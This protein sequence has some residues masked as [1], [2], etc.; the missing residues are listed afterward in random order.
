MV[1]SVFNW[2]MLCVFAMHW[3]NPMV[4]LSF[5]CVCNVKK[6]NIMSKN[7]FYLSHLNY[8]IQ[9]HFS[10]KCPPFVLVSEGV[11]FHTGSHAKMVVLTIFLTSLFDV[12]TDGGPSPY[13]NTHN[14]DPTT[15]GLNTI[16]FFIWLF[17]IFVFVLLW[18]HRAYSSIPRWRSNSAVSKN[19]KI[20]AP[21]KVIK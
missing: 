7:A 5:K 15:S 10:V 18:P 2:E 17:L 11:T 8:W 19:R 1:F 6:C 3:S 21:N 9:S 16:T 12:S 14:N 4:W 20:K 13:L